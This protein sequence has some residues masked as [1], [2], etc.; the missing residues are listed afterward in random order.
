[1]EHITE[2]QAIALLRKHIKNDFV[3]KIIHDHVQTVKNVA[4]QHAEQIKGI[5]IDFVKSA[6]LLHDIGRA[7]FPPRTRFSYKHGF[8]GGEILRKEGFPKHALVCERH[9]GFGITKEEIIKQ[10]LDLPKRDMMPLSAEEKIVCFAD[11]FVAGSKEIIEQEIRNRFSKELGPDSLKKFD[12]LIK[13][14]ESL[15]KKG[16]K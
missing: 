6:S 12:R 15:K 11:K 13:D 7:H 10:K 1:M 5:D 8:A 4:L 9:L 16:V 3:F 14:I 2:Q